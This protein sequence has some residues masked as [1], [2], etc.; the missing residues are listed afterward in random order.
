MCGHC[1]PQGG[2]DES[3]AQDGAHVVR[4]DLLLLHAAVVLQREDDRVF[5]SL[6][7]KERKDLTEC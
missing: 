6:K 4:H 2:S 3:A 5:G 1:V 7:V